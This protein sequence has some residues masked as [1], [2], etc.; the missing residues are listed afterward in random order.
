VHD[1]Y[2]HFQGV[3]TS[4]DILEAIVGVFRT[5]EVVP[6]PAVRRPDGSYLIS[7][8]MNA[9]DLM[10]LL[11]LP[12]ATDRQYHTAAGFVLAGFG[13][14]PKIGESF[15]AHGWRF[16]VVD[17]DG[18]RIDKILATRVAAGRRRALA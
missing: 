14:L 4:A 3:V 9:E 15:D 1:E 7:G 2:G 8:S 5:E 10:E 18:R 12:A 13:H 16:E 17:L 6:E 11:R